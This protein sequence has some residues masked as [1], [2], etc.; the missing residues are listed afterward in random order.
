VGGVDTPPPGVRWDGISTPPQREFI[1]SVFHHQKIDYRP[2]HQ[3]LFLILTVESAVETHLF[4][5]FFG[6]IVYLDI[7]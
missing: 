6:E 3:T 1:L 5:C 2:K 4:G 7:L